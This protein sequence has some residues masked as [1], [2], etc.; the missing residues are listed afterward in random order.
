MTTEVAFFNVP[1]DL[2]AISTS[3]CRHLFVTNRKAAE[4][5]FELFTANI[6]DRPRDG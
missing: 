6:R 3:R 2:A 5:F 1:R 4:R